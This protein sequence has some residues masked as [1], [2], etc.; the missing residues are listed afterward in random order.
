MD[1]GAWWVMFHKELD[2]TEVTEHTG[3]TSLSCKLCPQEVKPQVFFFFHFLQSLR[4][5]CVHQIVGEALRQPRR[6]VWQFSQIHA[7]KLDIPAPK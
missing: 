3:S 5:G 7:G 4:Q 1:R 2:M 6:F